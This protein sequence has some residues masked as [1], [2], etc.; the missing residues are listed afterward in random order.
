MKRKTHPTAPARK[1]AKQEE[2]PAFTT[3]GTKG[4]AKK[5]KSPSPHRAAEVKTCIQCRSELRS[6]MFCMQ[7]DDCEEWFHGNCVGITSTEKRRAAESKKLWYCPW[8]IPKYRTG[9]TILYTTEI[10]DMLL[11]FLSF[12]DLLVRF[13][14]VCSDW[15]ETAAQYRQRWVAIH[16]GLKEL[17]PMVTFVGE[18]TRAAK[19]KFFGRS[20]DFPVEIQDQSF[21][22]FP[23]VHIYGR[24]SI[25]DRNTDYRAGMTNRHSCLP[26]LA[27]AV[28]ATCGDFVEYAVVQYSSAA[29]SSSGR[30]W[31]YFQWS[32]DPG[33]QPDQVFVFRT[34]FYDDTV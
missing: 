12:K 20:Y 26:C 1:K 27:R 8:C 2:D 13:R 11:E 19:D 32:F 23:K 29:R 21:S 3:K 33:E 6:G 16:K 18:S 15:F 34:F 30:P 31:H 25:W 10:L 5:K 9:H 28:L 4:K 24:A 14:L 17:H 7:C 22:R